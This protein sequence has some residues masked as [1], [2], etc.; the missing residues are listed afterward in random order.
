MWMST[1]TELPIKA[2]SW[3]LPTPSAHNWPTLYSA[4]QSLWRVPMDHFSTYD[5]NY[6]TGT[7][8]GA[9]KSNE[10]APTSDKKPDDPCKKPGSSIIECQSQVLGE[11]VAITGTA[12]SLNYRSDRV[13]GRS[14][15][16]TIQI[17]LSG[18]TIPQGLKHIDLEIQIA[19]QTY[20]ENF[21]A[22]PE[23]AYS[24]TWDGKDAYGR[25]LQGAQN[26]SIRVG[27]VYDGYYNLPPYLEKSFGLQSGVTMP[28]LIPTRSDAILW[29]GSII[30]IG[31]WDT[32]VQGL[33]GWSLSLHHMYDVGTRVLYMGDGSRRSATTIN[34]VITTIA[35]NGIY[36]YGGDGGPAKEASLSIPI[37][38]ALAPDGSLYIADTNNHRIRR[39]GPDG[40]ITTITGN[41]IYGYGGDGGPATEAS[42]YSP[43]GIAL[44]P[45]GSLYIA[46]TGN[47][48]IRQGKVPIGLITT[49]AGNGN[50]VY[51]GDG[52]PA[53]EASLFFHLAS[54]WPR[55]AACTSLTEI[56]IESA[57]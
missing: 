20:K 40:L 10:P 24:F 44:A 32:R 19:G 21:P 2:R 36:G 15:S 31:T 28:E 55:T 16:K 30:R 27:Y 45:D 14:A 48:R 3:A 18:A 50:T 13:P 46:D 53:T 47:H 42:L 7:A 17:P 56:T 37:G 35:G 4:G 57:G 52:G 9:K 29:Q 23:Q 43:N 33:G 38:I 1:A 39:V 22:S 34:N 12:L 26:A 8:P 54:P 25:T 49:V 41:G 51:G 5:C 11:E 6:G